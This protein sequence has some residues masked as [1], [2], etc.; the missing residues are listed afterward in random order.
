MAL[1]DAT[2]GY[3]AHYEYWLPQLSFLKTTD[4]GETWNKVAFN[5]LPD[6]ARIV[7][8]MVDAN[9]PSLVYALTGKA[10]F[11]CSD[12]FLYRSTDSGQHWTRIATGI[13]SILDFDLHP[14]NSTT[15]YA[16]TFQMHEDGCAADSDDYAVDVGET[17]ISTNSG[18]S[19]SSIFDSFGGIISVGNNPQHISVTDIIFDQGTW[20]TTEGGDNW[21]HT[22]PRSGW[23]KGW[24]NDN[25]AFIPSYNGLNKTLI[26]DRFNPDKLYGAFGQWA[27]SSTDGGDHVNNI[28]TK[29]ITPNHFLSTGLENVHSNGMDVNDSDPNTIYL[30]GYDIGFWYSKNHGASWK[31]SL[32]DKATYPDYTWWDSG[33]SNCNFVLSDPA[34]PAVVWAAFANSQP[35][36]KS[37]IFKSTQSGE[38]W[39]K[40][41]T[42]LDDFGLY[43]HG[44]SID[45]QSDV[46]NR[47]LY[48]T[49]NGDVYKSTDGGSSWTQKTTVGGLKFTEVDK[50][51]SSLVYAGGENG[52]YRSTNGGDTWTDVSLAEMKFSTSVP[53][54]VMRPDIIPASDDL[55]ANPPIVAW[56]G[57]FDIRADP[58]IPN[59]VYATAFGP[60][61]GL[62]RSDQ[63][64]AAGTWQ[65]LY[66][67]DKMRGIAIAPGNSDILYLSSSANYHS[68]EQSPE[69][70]GILVSFDAG[71]TW[72]F[73]NDGM[74]WT[75]GGRLEVETGA[76][77]DIWVW[78]PGT[79]LQH[80]PIPNF[81]L[82]VTM[83]S[84]FSARLQDD[85]VLLQWTT[86]AEVQNAGFEISRSSDAVHWAHLQ[87]VPPTTNKQ[88]SVIDRHPLT[89]VSYYRL[90]QKD[91]DGQKTG[92][93]TVSIRY[94]RS[95]PPT[96]Y[97]NPTAG[98][99]HVAFAKTRANS[100]IQLKLF[101]NLGRLM[102]SQDGYNE[103]NISELPKGVYH[104]AIGLDGE[105]WHR[106][107]VRE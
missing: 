24:A 32:P 44:L 98:L 62:Y 101:D 87:D 79:G 50:F 31:K 21:T 33:G 92:L 67:N 65:K 37:A 2:I 15:I 6:T 36:V 89:G 53:N 69:S 40:S 56:Q 52:F 90:T 60:G 25:W 7:K 4:G 13:G 94:H 99:I 97:P 61:K 84:P 63:G 45:I 57:I 51:N 16:S 35:D 1:S 70:I 12:P 66:T 27:W 22:G 107:I 73:A 72:A 68:G 78:V 28:S 10:R 80:S 104:L 29:E 74:A 76:N 71:A 55:E 42:G 38:N 48:V 19:F 23:F 83:L 5:G 34:N 85:S 64:G 106:L 86:S 20:K 96:V 26:K 105:I 91:L 47:T 88:Y 30:G 100:D 41:N 46:N 43:T 54:A 9:T 58:N 3:M 49:Q 102:L 18:T 77:P 93:G 14:T 39:V 81:V 95:L 11:G 82:P 17:Y 103:L 8:I 59:R 75:N